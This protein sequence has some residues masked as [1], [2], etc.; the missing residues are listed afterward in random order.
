[1]A[2]SNQGEN[3]PKADSGQGDLKD[4]VKKVRNKTKNSVKI[5]KKLLKM[6]SIPVR[7]TI[8]LII[9]L[10]IAI[11]GIISYF[12]S[13]PGIIAGK[14]KAFFDSI[15]EGITGNVTISPEQ[16]NNLAEY[17]QKMG[18]GIQEFGFGNVKF[19][20]PKTDE[21]I[22]NEK[23]IDNSADAGNIEPK[24]KYKKVVE[25]SPLH[26]KSYLLA[27]LAADE[28]TYRSSDKAIASEILSSYSSQLTESAIPI[29]TNGAI[30]SEY[31]VPIH[32]LIKLRDEASD[33][34]IDRENKR[35]VASEGSS[36]LRFFGV[37]NSKNDEMYSF[38]MSDWTAI[39]GRP[40]ELSLALH[41]S[42]MMPDLAYEVATEKSFDTKV[43]INAQK[44]D[45]TYKIGLVPG[46]ELKNK[47][48]EYTKKYGD[49][50]NDPTAKG[51]INNKA[52]RN[53]YFEKYLPSDLRAKVV[54]EDWRVQQV[55]YDVLELYASQDYNGV[56]ENDEAS[57]YAVRLY[58]SNADIS[59]SKIKNDTLTDNDLKEI[60]LVNYIKFVLFSPYANSNLKEI[61]ED[62]YDDG[63]IEE[64]DYRSQIKSTFVEDINGKSRRNCI[65][66]EEIHN[67]ISS[68]KDYKNSYLGYTAKSL[69]ESDYKN[70]G[71]IAP[72]ILYSSKTDMYGDKTTNNNVK[73]TN[74]QDFLKDH[75]NI[76]MFNKY[77]FIVTEKEMPKAVKDGES[78]EIL[79]IDGNSITAEDLSTLDDLMTT[80]KDKT[81]IKWPYIEK[82]TKH[83]FYKT[84]NFLNGKNYGA[85]R[86]SRSIYQGIEVGGNLLDDA[87]NEEEKKELEE[88][89]PFLTNL[90]NTN[91]ITLQGTLKNDDG[92]F[93]QVCEPELEYPNE[94]IKSVFSRKYYRYDGT[95]ETARKIEIAKTLDDYIWSEF[96]S[97][98]KKPPYKNKED[99]VEVLKA[100]AAKD[101]KLKKKIKK[102]LEKK[103]ED[104]ITYN[105]QYSEYQITQDDIEEYVQVMDIAEEIDNIKKSEEKDDSNSSTQE[106]SNS[107]DSDESK[108]DI[109]SPMVKKYVNFENNKTQ[110]LS[111]LSLLE[112]MHNTCGDVTYREL[113][114]LLVN[115]KYYTTDEMN[116]T[117]RN[118]LLWVV[119]NGI[120]GQNVKWKKIYSN[121]INNDTKTTNKSTTTTAGVEETRNSQKSVDSN[122]YGLQIDDITDGKDKA[123][124]VAPGDGEVVEKTDTSVKIKLLPFTDSQMQI[125]EYRY[126]DDYK[127]FSKND[128]VGL[129]I[130]ISGFTV[131]KIGDKVARGDNIGTPIK[132]TSL[133]VIIKKADKSI[134][135]DIEDYLDSD[136]TKTDEN[137]LW[138]KYNLEKIVGANYRNSAFGLIK[139]S[140]N[141]ETV[142]L[143]LVGIYGFSIE[144]ACGALGNMMRESGVLPNNLENKAN[145]KSGM[146]DQEFTDKVNSGEID[147]KHF[148]GDENEDYNLGLYS[149]GGRYGYGIVQFTD[150]NLK[151]EL[152][153]TATKKGTQIDDLGTQL[154]VYMKQAEKNYPQMT[155][156]LRSRNVSVD[157]AAESMFY[158]YESGGG[159]IDGSLKERQE[160]AEKCYARFK[161]YTYD[162]IEAKADEVLDDEEDNDGTVSAKVKK[163]LNFA[164]K[165]SSKHLYQAGNWDCSN[166]VFRCLTDAGYKF[167]VSN[168]AT[169]DMEKILGAHGFKKVEY[170]Y[171]NLKKGDVLIWNR[172]GTSGFGQNGHTGMMLSDT[173]FIDEKHRAG[174]SEVKRYIGSFNTEPIVMRPKD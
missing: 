25:V 39:Y 33:L 141:T 111:I 54:K 56:A 114:S 124:I 170:S 64:S 24:G 35:I 2:N 168:F 49:S 59:I 19:E 128:L 77:D 162:E 43:Y 136:Y 22:E 30:Y 80:G 46:S 66:S 9:F 70:G 29:D 112:N 86:K 11:M 126:K 75:K 69:N 21:E 13:M 107:E 133:K 125:L 68:D 150:N 31:D 93:Y 97:E 47:M 130:D 149:P 52:I 28:A 132:G 142:F 154:Y 105:F 134:V 15:A 120:E 163:Y 71:C 115:L 45:V 156:K 159:H 65:I 169:P 34:T 58:N 89:H 109:E 23:K 51:D 40:V 127:R 50:K 53:I 101:D 3:V 82:V 5:T 95:M 117:E 20:E 123:C 48:D 81:K 148:I 118:L 6:V 139:G 172:P 131:G 96:S 146:S 17:I 62:K 174:K 61:V 165:N 85:Y 4:S 138:K 143:T 102:F 88:E 84:I 145:A 129:E 140:D 166:F 121:D 74:V 167:G 7:L 83:W 10:I 161:H 60:G 41:L 113:K 100:K 155:S 103:L 164:V 37:I 26:N 67:Y 94:N 16:V 147:R 108:Y 104:N 14:I 116:E 152:Y 106:E 137:N 38:D 144:G 8:I 110:S 78:P 87:S 98:I 171:K 157:A 122:E 55:L 119:D 32:G 72:M 158:W 27:Y 73:E 92:L 57:S 18:Y 1:M 63:K 42:T 173:K 99:N 151:Q 44:V 36:F 76:S 90:I 160:N 12:K 91:Q 135:N 79:N 153:D